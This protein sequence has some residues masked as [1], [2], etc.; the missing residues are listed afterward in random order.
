M[1]W[2]GRLF[3]GEGWLVY[4]GAVGPATWHA[5]HAFQLVR[6]LEEG[7][8]VLRGRDDG[9]GEPCLAAVVPS[10]VEH[11]TEGGC[12]SAVLVY[13]DPETLCGRRLRRLIAPSA[14]AATWRDL[15]ASLSTMP[16]SGAPIDWGTAATLRD[17]AIVALTAAA[18]AAGFADGAHMTRTFRRMFGIA[19]SD[20]AGYAT[21]V[22]PPDAN[23]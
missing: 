11:V 8:V 13:V 19:P 1:S 4:A 3:L 9:V 20:V 21:F 2:A 15:G 12:P 6:A 22:L 7:H 18:S 17:A 14:R 10:D 23:T 5:H 16:I